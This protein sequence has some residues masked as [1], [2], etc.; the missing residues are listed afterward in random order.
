MSRIDKNRVSFALV[1]MTRF[2]KSGS[3]KTSKTKAPPL[4]SQVRG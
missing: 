3:V 2:A 1:R 4:L